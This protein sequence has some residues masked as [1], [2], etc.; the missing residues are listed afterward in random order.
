MGKRRSARKHDPKPEHL[1]VYTAPS[2]D[3]NVVISVV[4]RGEKI[5]NI[6]S[7]TQARRYV[8]GIAPTKRY[9]YKITYRDERGIT[10]YLTGTTDNGRLDQ[11][12]II[13]NLKGSTARPTYFAK[14]PKRDEIDPAEKG[15]FRFET[16]QPLPRP[17]FR[18]PKFERL[19]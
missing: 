4:V 16:P 3:L 9:R 13:W 7:L 12:R 6:F 17:G 10:R 11:G 8:E 14:G 1:L 18:I 5:P 19:P 2:N 15:R